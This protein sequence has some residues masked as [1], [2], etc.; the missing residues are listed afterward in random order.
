MPYRVL[1]VCTGNIC[2]SPMAELLLRRAFED[3]GLADQVEVESAG[4]TSWEQGEPIDPRAGA[5]LA[6][7][8][9]DS[10]EHRASQMTPDQLRRSDLILALDRDHLGPLCR[11][12]GSAEDRVHLYREFDPE[13]HGDL[14]IRDPWYGDDADFSTTWDLLAAGAP[15]IVDFVRGQLA[16]AEVPST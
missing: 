5:V 9:I 7:H 6:E 14:G 16:G 8:G 13:A 12:A 1:A 11:M 3:A 10:A 15:G 2:R 4:T